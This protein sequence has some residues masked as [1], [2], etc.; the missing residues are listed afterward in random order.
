M[1]VGLL[2]LLPKTISTLF[3]ISIFCIFVKINFCPNSIV[4]NCIADDPACLNF[5]F[6]NL[7][8]YI[9]IFDIIVFVKYR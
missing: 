4:C 8:V 9:R 1:S 7:K 6:E 5:Y 3:F 2:S